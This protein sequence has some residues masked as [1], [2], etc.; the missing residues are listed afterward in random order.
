MIGLNTTVNIL[1]Q[2]APSAGDQLIGMLVPLG[3]IFLVFYFIMWRPQAK[4]QR[5]HQS[6]LNAL[7]SGDEIVTAG[8]VLGTVRGVDAEIVT[9]EVSKGTKIKVLKSQIRGSKE[10]VAPSNG[11]G[12]ES[13][14]S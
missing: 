1:A 3:L 9:L 7:K 10:S 13:S 2:A 5:E 11:G 14:E 6:F 4:R 12:G 8:G